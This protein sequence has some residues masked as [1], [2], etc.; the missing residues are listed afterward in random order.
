M[1]QLAEWSPRR[2]L[3][4][5]SAGALLEAAL[6]LVMFVLLERPTP[7]LVARLQGGQ[8]HPL[9]TV[10]YRADDL[11]LANAARGASMAAPFAEDSF[12]TVLHWPPHRPLLSG[13]GRVIAMPMHLWWVPALYVGAVPLGLLAVGTA[14]LLARRRAAAERMPRM[15]WMRGTDRARR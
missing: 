3:R 4:L 11:R 10:E 7:P 8:S 15:P 14:W 6:L 5:W 1:L 9:Q 13:G 12:Y 2:L